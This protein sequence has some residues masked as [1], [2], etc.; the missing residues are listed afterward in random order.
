MAEPGPWAGAAHITGNPGY[1][2]RRDPKYLRTIFWLKECVEPTNAIARNVWHRVVG[3]F[4]FRHDY[5]L[6]LAMCS[7]ADSQ[8]GILYSALA[9]LGYSK[10]EF[11]WVIENAS[12]KLTSQTKKWMVKVILLW[13]HLHILQSQ[14]CS[15]NMQGIDDTRNAR[16]MHLHLGCSGS[17]SRASAFS[18]V[19]KYSWIIW[20]K[21]PPLSLRWYLDSTLKP[22][23]KNHNTC[24]SVTSVCLEMSTLRISD[25]LQLSI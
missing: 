25:S 9:H 16:P 24:K 13:Q 7:L 12:H 5:S 10:V 4:S 6:K 18:I 2:G 22:N 17:I 23:L 14:N 3:G 19:N 1:A 21:Q 20:G 11:P 15:L 8:R